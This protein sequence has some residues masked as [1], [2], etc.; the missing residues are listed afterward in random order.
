MQTVTK[1]NMSQAAKD[2]HKVISARKVTNTGDAVS[3]CMSFDCSWNSR[4][5]QA[6]QEV[7]VAISQDNGKIVFVVHK[8]S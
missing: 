1:K 7:V 2:V 6:K 5:W 4:G 3:A 8:F